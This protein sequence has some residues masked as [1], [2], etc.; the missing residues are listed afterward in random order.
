MHSVPMSQWKE[1]AKVVSGRARSA[2]RL[3]AQHAGQVVRRD[4]ALEDGA[5]FADV[6]QATAY[7]QRKPVAII[8]IDGLLKRL[9]DEEYN[10]HPF[11][12]SRKMVV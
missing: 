12:C 5:R 2:A 8:E 4:W 1:Q 3:S 10:R 6:A 7:A 9:I 11:Y